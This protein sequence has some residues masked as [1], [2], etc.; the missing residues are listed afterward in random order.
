[1]RNCVCSL[2]N[3]IDWFYNFFYC[4]CQ[5]KDDLESRYKA[6]EAEKIEKAVK[7]EKQ[8]AQHEL[9]RAR[10]QANEALRALDGERQQLRAANNK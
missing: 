6:E 2:Q 4:F 1:M 7:A 9:E 10:H 3:P 5:E 8:A